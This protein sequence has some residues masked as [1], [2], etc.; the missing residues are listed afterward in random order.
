MA[1]GRPTKDILDYL[2][3][4]TK[5]HVG[6]EK[7]LK[8]PANSFL[9]HT[10]EAK[11][12]VEKCRKDFRKNR[13]TKSLNSSSKDSLQYIVLA[14]LPLIMGHFE[15]YQKYL[16]AGL[17]DMSIYLDKFVIKDFFKRLSE[18]KKHKRSYNIEINLE[19]IALYR[20]V[21]A[22]S[23]GLLLVNSMSDWHNPE[24]V[25]HY[26]DAFGLK[27]QLFSNQQ[28]E[29]IKILW[30]LRHSIVHNGGTLT[31]A[32]SQKNPKLANLGQKQLAFKDNF[33]IELCRKFHELIEEVNRNLHR[34]FC[35]NLSPSFA[36]NVDVKRKIDDFFTLKDANNSWLINSTNPS[37]NSN[38]N[39]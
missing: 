18:D 19:H 7:Y 9:V 27:N 16:F 1:Q 2:E 8:S 26:F 37:A 21:K 24:S 6:H 5:A 3:P 28:S 17:F 25:N 39:P 13:K 10:I 34:A 36:G 20:D 30:Q 35:N 12:A 31:L 38:V 11:D 23:M 22:D 14:T 32:D 33:I 4:P 29:W 15:T